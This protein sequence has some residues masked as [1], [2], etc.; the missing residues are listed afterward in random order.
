MLVYILMPPISTVAW[1]R[2]TH[3]T[4]FLPQLASKFTTT[5]MSSKAV[6]SSKLMPASLGR[7]TKQIQLSLIPFP[8]SSSDPLDKARA[9]DYC[10]RQLETNKYKFEYNEFSAFLTQ[11][12]PGSCNAALSQVETFGNTLRA[13]FFDITN[14]NGLSF[15]HSDGSKVD[16]AYLT[17]P[18]GERKEDIS[19]FEVKA[20][21][22][23]SRYTPH[24]VVLT[25]LIRPFTTVYRLKLPQET[26]STTPG[27]AVATGYSTPRK[28]LKYDE[29]PVSNNGNPDFTGIGLP[30][31]HDLIEDYDIEVIHKLNSQKFA[32]LKDRSE[33]HE[34]NLSSLIHQTPRLAGVLSNNASTI[35]TYTGAYDFMTCQESFDKTFLDRTSVGDDNTSHEKAIEKFIDLCM[36]EV[37]FQLVRLD[38]VGDSETSLT[39]ST[40]QLTTLICKIKMGSLHDP[41]KA[42]EP[43][44]PDALFDRFMEYATQLEDDTSTW[45]IVLAQQYRAALPN[46]Y[47]DDIAANDPSYKLPNP[48]LLTTKDSQLNALRVIRLVAIKSKKR[49]DLMFKNQS[50]FMSIY[51]KAAGKTAKG[52]VAGTVSALKKEVSFSSDGTGNG[53]KTTTS[54]MLSPAEGVIRRHSGSDSYSPSNQGNMSGS[55]SSNKI[56]IAPI[57]PV[58]VMIDGQAFPVCQVSN[59]QSPYDVSFKGCLGCGSKNHNSF[60]DCPSKNDPKVKSDFFK[61]L[62]A[63]KPHYRVKW[64]KAQEFRA[65]QKSVSGTAAM[66]A[67]VSSPAAPTYLPA[68]VPLPQ[69][70][71]P[72]YFQNQFPP[73]VGYEPRNFGGYG[74]SAPSVNQGPSFNAQQYGYGPMSPPSM[75]PPYSPIPPPFP[76]GQQ[77]SPAMVPSSLSFYGQQQ[78]MNQ[79]PGQQAT[80]GYVNQ[81]AAYGGQ[82]NQVTQPN[83]NG[84]ANGPATGGYQQYPPAN[85]SDV[86]KSS[87]WIQR[88]RCHSQR[89]AT[90]SIIPPMPISIDNGFPN[91]CLDLGMV[92]DYVCLNGLFDTCG[93][94]NTGYLPF[95]VWIASQYPDAVDDIRFFNSEDPFE[96]IKLE[97]AVSDPVDYD[98]SRH[99]LLTAVIRYRTPY[100][101]VDGGSVLLSIALGNNVS[102]NTI[103]GLPTL[104]AFEFIVNLKTL[105]A[106][107]PA[108]QETFQLTRS[109]GTLGLPAGTSFDLDD[110][111]RQFEAAKITGRPSIQAGT[112][113][114]SAGI[115]KNLCVGIDDFSLG[116]LRRSVSAQQNS[117]ENM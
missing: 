99:G 111:R 42:D 51:L 74:N 72:P 100:K 45:G 66:V 29:L 97:G 1:L 35:T 13:S 7:S 3:A 91:L 92:R 27:Q 37:L 16:Q 20:V 80:N 115:K 24:G 84:Q 69:P 12:I 34:K 90:L 54:S 116:Y 108:V 88:V 50:A 85:S 53:T 68:I 77:F 23:P 18:A 21:V 2:P 49:V 14:L 22:D 26:V 113:V 41:P 6:V 32:V 110:L 43:T 9:F 15:Q 60:Q 5:T 8:D 105:A 81:A 87:L 76:P 75:L 52:F 48:A 71:L 98:A 57:P 102:T 73:S 39:S 107:S 86:T 93:S 56:Y 117:S 10:K 67:G 40:E 17:K 11:Q 38:Y 70:P 103:F 82:P 25:N 65:Q 114:Q 62:H 112:V 47:V 59:F 109:A 44:N 106:I 19:L 79:Q 28:K 55:S 83:Q 94:L 63:H 78:Q 96:P 89:S 46:E 61:N 95:H 30:Q 101:T 64:E 36:L 58:T 33:E 4:S 31:G 104:Y